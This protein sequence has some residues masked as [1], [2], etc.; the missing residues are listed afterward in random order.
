MRPAPAAVP[1]G[2]EHA[3]FRDISHLMTVSSGSGRS[4]PLM[5]LE[6]EVHLQTLSTL[7]CLSELSSA[8]KIIMNHVIHDSGAVT[9]VAQ[10][11]YSSTI[12][13][14]MITIIIYK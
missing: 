4:V 7:L 3:T 2:D 12:I 6:V 10:C 5:R 9:A 8:P 14:T 1:C 11:T 13:V